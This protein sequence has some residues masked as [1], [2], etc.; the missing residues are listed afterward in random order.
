MLLDIY[1]PKK[2]GYEVCQEIRQMSEI[3]IVM[4][5]AMEDLDARLKGKAKKAT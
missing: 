5:T 2:D 4:L 3:P 1:M